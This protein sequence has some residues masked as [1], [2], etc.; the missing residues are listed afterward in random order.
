MILQLLIEMPDSDYGTKILF[1]ARHEK[2][3]ILHMLKQKA[4]ISFA[5]TAEVVIAFV[6]AT[7]IVRFLIFS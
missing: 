2:T 7:R 1:E 6:L 4:Q 3:N 5:N